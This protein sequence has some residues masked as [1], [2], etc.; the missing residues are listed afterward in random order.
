MAFKYK[1]VFPD[2]VRPSE[3]YITKHK[4]SGVSAT[5]S[6]A[7]LILSTTKI[8]KALMKF[9]EKWIIKSISYETPT[10]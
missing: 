7:A 9:K 10:R 4:Y 8:S 3:Q 6:E 1:I 5:K 2:L